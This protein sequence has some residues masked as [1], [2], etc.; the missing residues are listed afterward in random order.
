MDKRIAILGTGANGSCVAVDLVSA[1]HDVTLID[2]WPEHVEAMRANG[3]IVRWPDQE[4]HAGVDAHH[5]CDLCALNRT[6]DHVFLMV[7]AY[8]TGWAA[9]LIEPYLAPDGLM[10]GIQNAMTAGEIAEVVGPDRT[11]GCVIELSAELFTPGV[12]QRNTPPSGTWL[13]IGAL[14]AA[15]A[16]RLTEIEGILAD[17]GT[18]SVCDDIVAAK[19]MKLVV[20]SMSLGPVAMLGLPVA[21]AARLPG[22]RD[23][24]MKVGTESLAVGQRREYRIQPLFGLTPDDI[25]ESNRLLETL[26]DKLVADI[27]PTARDCV[28]QD[29]MKGRYS[30]VDLINGLVAEES[31]A[32][33]RP[34][35]ANAAVVEITRRIRNGELEPEPANFERAL[36]AMRAAV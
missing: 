13:G 23:F 29:H 28:L 31:L 19:W 34:A 22:F 15:M 27:G 3:L 18:V 20:N 1:G 16:G 5:L 25:A 36:D 8:D 33:G 6:F 9:R 12:A 32:A 35:P 14:D 10:V 7:K 30:E 4:V 26:F 11:V 24:L 2:Q 21:E 17:V